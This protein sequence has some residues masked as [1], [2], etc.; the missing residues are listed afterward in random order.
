MIMHPLYAS[1]VSQLFVDIV[2]DMVS[3]VIVASPRAEHDTLQWNTEFIYSHEL[4]DRYV[5]RIISESSD[6]S[7][8]VQPRLR[9][10][11]LRNRFRNYMNRFRLYT[12]QNQ[13]LVL[14]IE[15]AANTVV[16]TPQNL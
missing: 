1:G 15:L 7:D 5:A 13:K 6:E 12:K 16:V 10:E 3:I 2:K 8:E 4:E 11:Y 14:K 9:E